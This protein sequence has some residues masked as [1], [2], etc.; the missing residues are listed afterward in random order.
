MVGRAH[1][2][3]MT[4]GQRRVFWLCIFAMTCGFWMEASGEA[5]FQRESASPRVA[6]PWAR[7]HFAQQFGIGAVF[8]TLGTV[9]TVVLRKRDPELPAF[10]LGDWLALA[11]ML[12]ALAGTA[13]KSYAAVMGGGLT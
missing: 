2:I 1:L 9:L 10:H 11:V 8:L 13:W 4:P 5:L 3:A 6:G 12:G 7:E